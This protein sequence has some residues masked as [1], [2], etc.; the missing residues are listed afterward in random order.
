MIVW[1]ST[2]ATNTDVAEIT[3]YRM[4]SASLLPQPNREVSEAFLECLLCGCWNW[5]YTVE[6]D[7]H[8][9]SRGVRKSLCKQRWDLQSGNQ[10]KKT[11]T[12]PVEQRWRKKRKGWV[13]GTER[14]KALWATE[15]KGESQWGGE[16]ID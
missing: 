9:S 14:K 10:W 5:R 11:S 2:M 12:F 16:A 7:W 1:L 6:S 4:W 13:R 8:P 15:P 3:L